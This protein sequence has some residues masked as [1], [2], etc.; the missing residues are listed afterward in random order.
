MGDVFLIRHIDDEIRVVAWKNC[1]LHSLT[2]GFGRSSVVAEGLLIHLGFV[3][4][5]GALFIL[6]APSAW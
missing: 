2:S 4:E 3:V 1:V 6:A 5:N